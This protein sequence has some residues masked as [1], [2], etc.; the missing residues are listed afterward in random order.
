MTIRIFRVSE[1]D[2]YAAETGEQAMDAFA[3]NAEEDEFNE[4]EADGFPSVVEDSELDK[5]KVNDEGRERTMTWRELL[6]AMVADGVEF[7]AFFGSTNY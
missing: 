4:A 5:R 6:T 3:V 2:W 7:P 1:T